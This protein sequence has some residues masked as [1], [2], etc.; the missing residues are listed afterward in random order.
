MRLAT[1]LA[2]LACVWVACAS[3]G[4]SPP[5]NLAAWDQARVTSLAQQLVKASDAWFMAVR[6][7]P[8]GPVGLGGSPEEFSLANNAQLIQEHAR[9]LAGHLEKGQGYG[10]T[11][12]FFMTLKELVDDAQEGTER[13]PME[14][15]TTAAWAGVTGL[16]RQ[17][18]AYYDPKAFAQ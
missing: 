14:D 11:R 18:A 6:E 5:A 7:A 2:L 15:Q 4:G 1:K 16:M 13:T 17:L 12:D 3:S 9:E 10:E 8:G